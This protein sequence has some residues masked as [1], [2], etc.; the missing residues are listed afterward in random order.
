[1][2]KTIV[3]V[4]P[5]ASGKTALSI[6]IA[7]VFNGEIIS[8]DSIQVYKELSIGSA[9]ITE[10]EKQGIIHHLIDIKSCFE[11]FSA[12]EFSELTRKTIYEIKKRGK[13]PIIA[14]GTGLFIKGVIEGYDYSDCPKNQ[15]FR[16]QCHERI[17]KEGLTP[18]YEELIVLNP[19]CINKVKPN[20]EKRI[21]RQL[22]IAKFSNSNPQKEINLE[23]FIVIG[24]NMDRN[25]L[26]ERI[27]KR[28]DIMLDNG[29]VEE[30]RELYEKGLREH[31]Q[32]AKGI[33]YK[34]LFP[35]FE[36]I[37]SLQECIE[38]IKQHSRN[39]AKRQLTWFRAMPYI[40]WF[41]P[42]QNQE[43]ISY[44]RSKI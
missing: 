28:V 41:E 43:I 40:K 19:N 12:G 9:K 30:V 33:G 39:F 31:H 16:D 38:D 3:I 23:D 8:G 20:D 29:L 14:G 6:D 4:G 27:N 35:Y 15:R 13:T 42:N 18:L 36:G 10:Q 34:E 24:I 37:K 5:T 21:I 7:K 11:E 17:E 26:Y 44:I 1:M 22:E 25:I 32:S 2:Q